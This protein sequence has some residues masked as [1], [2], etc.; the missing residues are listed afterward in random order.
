MKANRQDTVTLQAETLT[1]LLTS[2]I[3]TGVKK[4]DW[5]SFTC[6]C[7]RVKNENTPKVEVLGYKEVFGILYPV[8]ID[9][10]N[11]GRLA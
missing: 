11:L 9:L 8:E 2:S 3:S 4:I 1:P 7:K 6:S 5:A 10:S